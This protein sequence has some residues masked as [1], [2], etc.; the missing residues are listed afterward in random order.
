M[1][2]RG[3]RRRKERERVERIFEEIMGENFPNLELKT[4]IQV[5]EA[6]RVPNKRNP[7]RLTPR[8]I[9]LKMKKLKRQ[10]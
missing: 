6:Q 5:L 1:H 10:S 9:V 2:Y 8:H 3:S 4:D 7:K